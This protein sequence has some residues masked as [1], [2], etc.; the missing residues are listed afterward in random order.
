MG[1]QLP[2]DPVGTVAV[3]DVGAHV[4]LADDGRPPLMSTFCIIFEASM[5]TGMRHFWSPL[6]ASCF[7]FICA[8]KA[9][10]EIFFCVDLPCAAAAI[11]APA[12]ATSAAST[13]KRPETIG[14]GFAEHRA[15]AGP[16]AAAA[17]PDLV[18]IRRIVVLALDLVVVVE[19][20]ARLDVAQRFDEDAPLLDHGLA[21]RVAGVVDVA[22]L[23]AA[24][25]RVDHRALVDDEEERVV[26]RL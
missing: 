17:G 21:V 9:S 11:V 3:V 8:W 15:A 26:V 20:F 18:D 25:A 13:M 14:S 23:V 16:G 22:R 2:V 1:V 6:Q 24:D 12:A 19:L 10:G 5:A 4:L 7:A